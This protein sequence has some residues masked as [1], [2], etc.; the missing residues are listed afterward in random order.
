MRSNKS[1]AKSLT[2]LTITVALTSL[3]IACGP[4]PKNHANLA[5]ANDPGVLEEFT[6]SSMLGGYGRF[7]QNGP[8]TGRGQTPEA[9]AEDLGNLILIGTLG[10]TYQIASPAQGRQILAPLDGPKFWMT[11]SGPH[12]ETYSLTIRSQTIPAGKCV[13]NLDARNPLYMQDQNGRV[14]LGLGSSIAQWVGDALLDTTT[15]ILTSDILNGRTR[16]LPGPS[17][18]SPFGT[19]RA[20]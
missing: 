9:C 13:V 18:A 11:V 14:V 3:V 15:A 16:I 5:S 4:A 20:P 6:L 17:P 19:G 1:L 12:G 10:E 2:G 8:L 7:S